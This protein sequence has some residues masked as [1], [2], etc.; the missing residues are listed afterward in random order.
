MMESL[1]CIGML[2]PANGTILPVCTRHDATRWRARRQSH[3]K[4]TLCLAVNC[5]IG[6]TNLDYRLTT[7]LDKHV[8]VNSH[9]SMAESLPETVDIVTSMLDVEVVQGGL[10]EVSI[11]REAFARQGTP[12]GCRMACAPSAAK[13]CPQR[14]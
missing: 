5:S 4:E 12:W 1:Y 13:P 2:H 10:L 6:R 7:A 3:G 8:R 14:G 9:S 11:A